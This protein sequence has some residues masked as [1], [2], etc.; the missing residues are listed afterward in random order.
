MLAH[1]N[2]LQHRYNLFHREA[3]PLHGKSPFL[4]WLIL[5][6]TNPH[7]VSEI[8]E[9]ITSSLCNAANAAGVRSASALCGRAPRSRYPSSTF[10]LH[11]I[12][13]MPPE[14]QKL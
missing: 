11:G 4:R 14:V 13:I 5:P 1:R 12:D 6:E 10:A 8:G 9:P 2:L 3:F 7:R